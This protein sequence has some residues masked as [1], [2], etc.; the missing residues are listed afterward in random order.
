MM[1]SIADSMGSSSLCDKAGGFEFRDRLVGKPDFVVFAALKDL[2]DEF[3][4]PI[5]GGNSV[6]NSAGAAQIIGGDGI[7]VADHLDIHHLQTAFDQHDQ[8]PLWRDKALQREQVPPGN[9]ISCRAKT[10]NIGRGKTAPDARW[11]A[12]FDRR[13]CRSF[14]TPAWPFSCCGWLSKSQRRYRIWSV[15]KRSRRCSDLFRVANSSVEMPPTC[16]T[17]VTCF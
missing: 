1:R 7:G 8:P 4:Q 9:R 16:F 6:G 11:E 3:E 15:Q 10:K 13:A 5:I 14:E 12:S 17:V 2:D